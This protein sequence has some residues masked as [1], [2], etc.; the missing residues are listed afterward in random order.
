MAEAAS[1]GRTGAVGALSTPCTSAAAPSAAPTTAGSVPGAC[2][3]PGTGEGRVAGIAKEAAAEPEAV[4]EVAARKR[5]HR[6]IFRHL[7]R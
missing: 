1:R 6:G 5:R 3:V 4:L 7:R 2:R